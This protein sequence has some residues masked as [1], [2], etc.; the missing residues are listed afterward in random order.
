LLQCI[1]EGRVKIDVLE[2]SFPGLSASQKASSRSS[3]EG[4]SLIILRDKNKCAPN[5]RHLPIWMVSKLDPPLTA[6][7]ES[8]QGT[9]DA[10]RPVPPGM[11]RIWRE[12]TEKLEHQMTA[13]AERSGDGSVAGRKVAS[14]AGCKRLL[15]EMT[16]TEAAIG[17]GERATNITSATKV[18]YF[19]ARTVVQEEQKGSARRRWPGYPTLGYSAALR[20][21]PSPSA[22][23]APR[24]HWASRCP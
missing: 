5:K 14:Y 20:G 2:A 23:M 8:M 17:M 15:L 12:F 13:S 22:Y 21:P 18:P 16:F 24:L 10:A 9:A 4:S 11:E 19:D 3:E 1:K 7:V 6:L